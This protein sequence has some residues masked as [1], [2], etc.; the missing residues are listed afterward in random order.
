LM[1]TMLVQSERLT[2]TAMTGE[3]ARHALEPSNDRAVAG[4]A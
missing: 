3:G 1:L 2:S 4:A